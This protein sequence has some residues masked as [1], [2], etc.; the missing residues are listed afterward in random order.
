MFRS[1]L[2]V[3]VVSLAGCTIA[4]TRD[5]PGA[6]KLLQQGQIN[7]SRIPAFVDCLV[8]GFERAHFT[9]T[10][11]RTRQRRLANG[12]QRV[13][14]MVNATTLVSADVASD[15]RAQIFESRVAMLTDTSGERAA[16]AECLGKEGGKP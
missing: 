16:F 11:I 9:L 14:S 5:E 13:E 15:G 1:V 8:D 6:F 2:A 12:M 4:P 3:A 7:P 10:N